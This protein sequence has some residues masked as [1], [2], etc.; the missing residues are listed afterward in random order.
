M[1]WSEI[2]GGAV[3]AN[4]S[5]KSYGAPPDQPVVNQGVG[6]WAA[7]QGRVPRT[8]ME[9][10][11]ETGSAFRTPPPVKE[12]PK[13]PQNMPKKTSP[14]AQEALGSRGNSQE[15]AA[16]DAG[17][18]TGANLASIIASGAQVTQAA[19]AAAAAP[20][21]AYSAAAA[22]NLATGAGAAQAAAA[23]SQAASAGAQAAGAATSGTSSAWGALGGW[24]AAVVMQVINAGTQGLAARKNKQPGETDQE[25]T[26]RGVFESDPLAEVYPDFIDAEVDGSKEI[27]KLFKKVF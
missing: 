15:G 1:V 3:Q 8:F 25:A 22:A 16:L 7:Q 12:K 27:S 10:Y 24:E 23:G 20:G 26:V 5:L 13:A 2:L 6:P 18:E 9:Q 11:L 19:Q 4:S 21:A 14:L 17:I